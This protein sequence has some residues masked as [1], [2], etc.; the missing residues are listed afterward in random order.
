MY[1]NPYN[2]VYASQ[3]NLDRINNQ[4]AEL[5][6]MKVQV[7]QQQMPPTQPA[8]NQ[9]F[10][11]SP[12]HPNSMKFVESKDDV[13]KELV[14]SDTPFFSKDLS[15]MWIKNVKGDVR[16]FELEEVVEKDEKDLMIESLRMQV[17]DLRKELKENARTDDEFV[18]ESIE[19]KKSSSLPKNRT[20]KK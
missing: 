20:T 13:S 12:N 17:Q 6:R 3:A 19:D 8:I 5:E 15:I 11:I 9:T 7:A 10:Q 16:T 2:N 1:N 14:I 18:D 4:I